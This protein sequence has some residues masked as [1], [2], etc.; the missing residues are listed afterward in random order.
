MSHLLAHEVRNPLHGMIATLD[1]LRE[2]DLDSDSHDLV[3]SAQSAATSVVDVLSDVLDVEKWKTSRFALHL[4]PV[5]MED[6]LEEIAAAYRVMAQV[7]LRIFVSPEVSMV[8]LDRPKVRQLLVNGLT[9]ASKLTTSGCITLCVRSTGQYLTKQFTPKHI[10][11]S[12]C[13][14]ESD[15]ADDMSDIVRD[16]RLRYA[17]FEVFDTGPGIDDHKQGEL[18][19]LFNSSLGRGSSGIG[20]PL[21]S[22]IVSSCGG[23]IGLENRQS[24]AACS[25]SD[26]S[27]GKRCENGSRHGARFWFTFP[28][29]PI[30]SDADRITCGREGVR[31]QRRAKRRPDIGKLM[32]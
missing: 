8:W 3:R 15:A 17:L 7:P 21:C 5:H 23:E 28:Y 9:N 6:L 18:F 14:K 12:T 13:G 2:K 16:L 11:A 25:S 10:T 30:V 32:H 27:Q 4:T 19:Q 24:S 29:A 1:A 26:E 31:G 22:T 20:L